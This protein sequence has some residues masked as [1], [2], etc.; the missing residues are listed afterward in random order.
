MFCRG[1]KA[2]SEHLERQEGRRK[3]VRLLHDIERPDKRER[4][5]VRER[6]RERERDR[7]RET[8]WGGARGGGGRGG[9]A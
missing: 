3:S 9:K 1:K 7:E 4:E 8:D 2:S 5:R 6:E